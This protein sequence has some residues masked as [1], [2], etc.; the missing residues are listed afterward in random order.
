MPTFHL[1]KLVRDKIIQHQIDEGETVDFEKLSKE[2]LITALIHKLGEEST[3]IQDS[4]NP[5]AELADV[6]QVID[7]LAQLL[8]VTPEA[9]RKKQAEKFAKNGGFLKG[10][11]VRSVTCAEDDKWTAYY[12]QEPDRFPETE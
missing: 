9:I 6:Q 5:T 12:R 8:N 10:Q 2:D 3:E 1:N 7:D 11:F 4:D